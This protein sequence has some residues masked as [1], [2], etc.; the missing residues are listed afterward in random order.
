MFLIDTDLLSALRRRERNPG[1]VQWVSKQRTTDLFL[2]VVSVGEIERGIARQHGRDPGFARALATWLDSVLRVYGERILAV[3]ISAARRWGRLS[4][5][6]RPRQRGLADR[7]DGT[8][9][10]L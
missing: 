6:P 8:R 9:A 4:G 2:S 3:E 10:W 5:V 7:G 1:I